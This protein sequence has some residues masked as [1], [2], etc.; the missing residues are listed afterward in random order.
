MENKESNKPRIYV[1]STIYD[2]ADL[3]SALKYWLEEFDFE[4]QMSEFNDF[5]V[6]LDLSSFQAC[7]DSMKNCNFFILLI[8]G[9]KGAFFDEK[10]EISITQQEYRTAYELVKKGKI[11]IISFIRKS[12]WNV[13]EDR[14]SLSKSLKDKNINKVESKIIEENP[15]FIFKFIDEVRRAVETKKAIEGKA[16]YPVNNWIYLFDNFKDVF[17]ALKIH[18]NLPGDLREKTIRCNL[19]DELERNILNS[20]I[21]FKNGKY[22]GNIIALLNVRNQLNIKTTDR[23]INLDKKVFTLMSMS[24][25]L[26]RQNFKSFALKEAIKSG[27]FLE[28]NKELGKYEVGKAQRLLLRLNDYIE[29]IVIT[30]NSELLTSTKNYLI[31]LLDSAKTLP[32]T[33]IITVDSIYAILIFSLANIYWNI[34]QISTF[35][36]ELLDG[37]KPRKI[38]LIPVDI[39][40][41]EN[42]EIIEI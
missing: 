31:N 22:N 35:I 13:K 30:C 16:K 42:K 1:S 34:Y 21:K 26:F 20:D 19:K 2:F 33:S 32:D 29:Q 7:L 28:Y 41:K 38:E 8:G 37:E 10:D 9:R 4:V 11:K 12:V 18:L 39:F 40:S 17:D 3:R 15:E 36:C 27:I 24:F 23:Y 14:K 5:S 6:N 25:I